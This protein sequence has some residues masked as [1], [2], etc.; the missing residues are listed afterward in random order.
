MEQV[1]DRQTLYADIC[2]HAQMRPAAIAVIDGL[3][4]IS[5][6]QFA[7]DIDN[8]SRRLHSLNL[9]HDR[10]VAI[11]VLPPYMHWLVLIALWRIGVPSVSIDKAN[12]FLG[13]NFFKPHAVVADHQL[14]VPF[15]GT[16]IRLE[17]DWLLEND[18]LFPPFSNPSLGPEQTIRLTSSS[19]TSGLP[20]RMAYNK[21]VMEARLDPLRRNPRFNTSVWFMSLV[22]VM[23]VE[24]LLSVVVWSVGGIVEFL[25]QPLQ[26]ALAKG[27]F[28]ANMVF[29]NTYQ[30]R[31]LVSDLPA[32]SRPNRS[33]A[34]LVG[35]SV[36]PKHV[37]SQA[38]QRLAGSVMIL[39]GSTE[40]GLVA[41][42]PNPLEYSDP[43]VCGFVVPEM[44]IQVI[45]DLG[46]PVGAGVVGEIRL[47]STSCVSSY[48]DDPTATDSAFKNGWFYP[49]DLGRLSE[50]GLLSLMGRVDEVMNLGG[51]KIAPALIEEALVGCGG[52]RDLAVCAVDDTNGLDQIWVGVVKGDG[53]SQDELS[54][55]W[56]RCGLPATCSLR[57]I[58]VDTIPRN[59][60]GQA[61]R[62]ELSELIK[63]HR[64]QLVTT[65]PLKDRL[66]LR[67]GGATLR[68]SGTDIPVEK[69]SASASACLAS[70][71]L[72]DAEIQRLTQ[73]MAVCE[74]SKAAYTTSLNQM[75][76]EGS[77]LST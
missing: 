64:G 70:L 34:I 8:V 21:R 23:S 74:N 76:I 2:R 19:G 12:E 3:R 61:L 1:S 45:N 58:Y 65:P 31:D 9:P 77:I 67:D 10:V 7:K 72:V 40:S 57:V 24:F 20:R 15:D 63:K 75:F 39:Y 29:M 35:G 71:Q 49:G 54:V 37:Y 36:V 73:Q 46:Y 47:R 17:A 60:M 51:F 27:E 52:I 55:H 68:L 38:L 26:L 56:Q 69:L 16:W 62:T 5:Y 53:F 32:E 41:T 42:N 18:S 6:A 25:S 44:E 30:L 50:N 4:S 28:K 33:L 43:G 14:D 22:N 59:A 48:E 66:E 11:S 13:F